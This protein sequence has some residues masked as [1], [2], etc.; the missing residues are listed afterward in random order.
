MRANSQEVKGYLRASARTFVRQG[1][2][3]CAAIIRKVVLEIYATS[4][5]VRSRSEE[6]IRGQLESGRGVGKRV[7]LNDQAGQLIGHRGV[8]ASLKS[9]HETGAF[10]SIL[11]KAGAPQEVID[12]CAERGEY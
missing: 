5:H 10:P 3:C 8:E 1:N 9:I 4:E 11:E 2:S 6:T 12:I 7:I